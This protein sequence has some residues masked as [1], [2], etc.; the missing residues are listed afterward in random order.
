MN[1]R[2]RREGGLRIAHILSALRPS[3]AERMLQCSFEL[4]RDN[5]IEP[6]VVGL[7]DEPHPFAETLRDAGYQTVVV[8]RSGRSLGGLVALRSVL[9][10]LRPDIVHVHRESMF[11]LI[12]ALA[13]ATPDVHGVV[14]SIHSNFAYRGLLAPR[15]TLFIH[16]AKALGVVSVACS[17]G[18]AGDEA[19]RYHHLP[20]VVENWVDVSAFTDELHV[21]AQARAQLDLSPDDF[22]VM[23]LGNCSPVKRH[24]VLL[25]AI[26]TVRQPVVV[27]HVGEEDKAEEAERAW[28]RS[29]AAPHR[30][31]RLGRR[32]NVAALL[33]AADVLAMPSDHREGFALAA[34]ESFCAATPVM[35]SA[36]PGLAWVTDFRTGCV[37]D[38]NPSAWANALER[39][40]ARRSDADWTKGRHEDAQV[41]RRRFS[42]ERGVTEWTY[43]YD[44]ATKWPVRPARVGDLMGTAR[45]RK[46]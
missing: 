4:W 22:V 23:L 40:A 44:L 20:K 43:L 24:V 29:V 11:P 37:I 15:R 17:E 28:W 2:V 10:H 34:A 12:C 26:A 9:A 27:L 5:G 1:L 30:L 19:R 31:I 36:A 3:G 39:V 33:A 8:P 7:S 14:R 21:R 38:S 32:D 18:V 25:E 41:A 16:A 13:R 46:S 35:A 6:V 42:P 45:G